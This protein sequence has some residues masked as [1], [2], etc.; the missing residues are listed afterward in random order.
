MAYDG[1]KDFVLSPF[2]NL[3]AQRKGTAPQV[4]FFLGL[5]NSSLALRRVLEV[6]M[7]SWTVTDVADGASYAVAVDDVVILAGFS[8][9]ITLPAASAG[10]ML[11]VKDKSGISGVG[12]QG[13]TINRSPA[14]S[15]TIDGSNTSFSLAANYGAVMFIAGNSTVWY[16]IALV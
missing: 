9:T 7:V 5:K 6:F 4:P 2:K 12:S 11:V 10:R 14:G 8:S 16:T 3:T 1:S 13:I 15:D